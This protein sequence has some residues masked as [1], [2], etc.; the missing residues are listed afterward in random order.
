M[1]I[2]VYKSGSPPPIFLYSK[3]QKVKQHSLPGWCFG[4]RGREWQFSLLNDEQ[5]SKK[6]RVK[7]LPL[8]AAMAL[9]NVGYWCNWCP[10]CFSVPGL[11]QYKLHGFGPAFEVVIQLRFVKMHV[12][13]EGGR[14]RYSLPENKQDPMDNG[15]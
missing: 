14:V 15:Q 11:P 12:N 1:I 8:F 10:H 4:M 7:H 13:D 9:T 6:V 5:I 3:M 2:N